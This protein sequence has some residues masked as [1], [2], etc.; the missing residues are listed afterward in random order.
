MNKKQ[1]ILIAS[2][3]HFVS[4]DLQKKALFIKFIV[5]LDKRL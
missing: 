3:K 2:G 4:L 5:K 1:I